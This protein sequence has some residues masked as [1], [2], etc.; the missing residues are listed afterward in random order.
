MS[1]ETLVHDAAD[2]VKNLLAAAAPSAIG[3]G[4]SALYQRGLSFRDWCVQ[5]SVGIAVSW[6]F[7]LGFAAIW[8]WFT[9]HPADPFALQSIRFVL[10]LI[11]FQTTPRFITG[12]GD[13]L[14]ALPG[15]LKDRLLDLIPSR[16]PRP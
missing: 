16:R 15:G 2:A 1:I 7:G 3:A 5:C 10:G 14:A 4:V 13:A 11:A 6:Y 8:G 12:A 9:G